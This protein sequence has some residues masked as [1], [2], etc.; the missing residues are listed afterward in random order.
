MKQ[1]YDDASIQTSVLI[2]KKY[3]TS[4][5]LGIRFLHKQ[6]HAPIY[7]IYGY[8]RVADEIVDSFHGYDKRQLLADFRQDTYKAIRSGIST[9]PVLQSFQWA[10]N[11]YKIPVELIDTFLDSMAMDLE[12]VQYSQDNFEKYILGSAE[13]VGL[14]CLKV[15]V[16]GDEKQY[17]ELKPYAMKLGAAFQKINFLRDLKD[18]YKE[19]GRTYF[20]GVDFDQFDEEL[21]MKLVKDMEQDFYQG[22]LGIKKLPKGSRFGVY[23]A[24]VYYSRLL[25]KI[26]LTESSRI[27]NERIRIP[28]AKKY[29][30]FVSSYVR[31]SLNRI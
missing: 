20:P 18:D 7:A 15:F 19:L 21:K 16:E 24:Y 13:V 30:L 2:T 10:V 31:H 22:Y 11:T 17:Q 23:I 26:K 4:F 9:N 5:S 3:S 14:M 25:Q 6:F 29:S 28:N 1:L 12:D 27:L 8:V